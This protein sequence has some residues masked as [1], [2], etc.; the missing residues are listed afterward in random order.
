MSGHQQV[1]NVPTDPD[2]YSSCQRYCV[3]GAGGGY[4]R[5]VVGAEGQRSG[6]LDLLPFRAVEHFGAAVFCRAGVGDPAVRQLTTGLRRAYAGP[7]R[8]R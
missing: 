7:V 1:N 8:T 4:A 2:R 3:F 6:L 5:A